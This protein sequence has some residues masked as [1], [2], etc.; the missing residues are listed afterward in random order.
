MLVDYFS[1]SFE[2][3]VRHIIKRNM[4]DK[5]C[6]PNINVRHIILFHNLRC[7]I[8]RAATIS[9]NLSFIIDEAKL[10]SVCDVGD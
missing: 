10:G 2:I 5:S 6:S 7:R 9:L 8:I 4:E 3:N 1:K